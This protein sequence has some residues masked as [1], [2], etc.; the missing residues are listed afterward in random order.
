M[1]GFEQGQQA[2]AAA[3]RDP[4]TAPPRNIEPPRSGA[5]Q[6]RFNVY[7]NN[8][9][10][11]LLGVL[12]ARYPAV[13]RILGEEFFRAM[14]RIFIDQAPPRSPVLLEYGRGFAEFLETFEPI[15]DE[16]YL[17][18]VARL[19]WKMHAARHAAD[20][21]AIRAG[22]LAS[23]GENAATLTFRLAA[24][25]SLVASAYPVFSLW[26]ANTSPAAET[27]PLAFSGRE[28]VLVTRPALTPEAVRIPR[29]CAVFVK[30]LMEDETLGEAAAAALEVQPD[31]PLNRAL[32]LLVAQ[33]A[34]VSVADTHIDPEDILP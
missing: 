2:F 15:S 20:C 32:A 18:D 5:T 21:S 24:A 29:A 3:L 12:E 34:I 7:R 11:G 10:A 28:C 9:Y 1:S 25:V 6:R 23:Y 27:G 17:P 16:P 26:R 4:A 22:D 31:F 19:E 14:A 8:V 33:K 30:A 13:Q